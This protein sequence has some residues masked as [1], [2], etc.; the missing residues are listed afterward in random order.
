MTD[1]KTVTPATTIFVLGGEDGEMRAIRALLQRFGYRWVQP[2]QA[3]GDHAFTPAQCGL[4][5]ESKE[6]SRQGHS[7]RADQIDGLHQAVFVECRA[8]ES[9]WPTD[10]WR[11]VVIDHHGSRSGEVASIQQVIDLLGL[12]P[13]LSS[14]TQR[15]AELIAVNDSGWI[16]GLQAWG[17]TLEEIERVRGFDRAAQGITPV[18]ETEVERALTAPEEL[19]GAIRIVRMSHSKTSPLGDR[20]ALTAMREGREAPSYLALSGDGEVNFSG[21]GAL[22]A[23]LATRFQ[24]WSGGS[25]LGKAGEKAFWGGYPS[26]EEVLAFI[27][28]HTA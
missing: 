14:A 8:S 4:K 1:I 16:P 11:S 9:G 5:V 19:I 15:W 3:W 18:H 21:D 7:Y 22:A 17:A 13:R 28:E 10:G 26:H 23:A 12:W 20:L 6:L 25:G 27:R 2:N 24:G